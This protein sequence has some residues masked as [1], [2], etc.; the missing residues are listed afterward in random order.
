[1][2][3]RI[4]YL[5]SAVRELSAEELRELLAEAQRNN[6]RNGITGVLL[7]LNG[8]FLQFLEGPAQAVGATLDRIRKDHRHSG[9]FV[10]NDSEVE[11]A[12][13]P[14]W[15]MGFKNVSDED[16]AADGNLFRLSADGLRN[17]FDGDLEDHVRVFVDTFFRVNDHSVE[18]VTVT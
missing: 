9:V 16:L 12:Q 10:L 13:F 7:Y 1:M 6:G 4:I 8:N 3:R 11:R 17:M 5:S 14:G 2:L 15:S 18:N